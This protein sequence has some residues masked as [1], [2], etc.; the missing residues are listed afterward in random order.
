MR[1]A[2][3][4]YKTLT[5]AMSLLPYSSAE[6]AE[7]IRQDG[8]FEVFGAFMDSLVEMNSSH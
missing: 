2:E 4:D 3:A 1:Q 8:Q 7:L 5:K 6:L